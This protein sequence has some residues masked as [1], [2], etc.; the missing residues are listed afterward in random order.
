MAKL[1]ID[2][3]V[4]GE[5]VKNPIKVAKILE[6]ALDEEK[7]KEQKIGML[8]IQAKDVPEKEKE[9]EK[10]VGGFEKKEGQHFLDV[11]DELFKRTNPKAHVFIEE[12]MEEVDRLF[13]GVI[14]AA[15]KSRIAMF[16]KGFE[17]ISVSLLGMIRGIIKKALYEGYK[18]GKRET[19]E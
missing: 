4:D 11:L 5:R 1:E 10:K 8:G 12:N 17:N 7:I 14:M 9:K 13:W 6:K 2:L 15:R 19:E 18:I 16:D 3:V